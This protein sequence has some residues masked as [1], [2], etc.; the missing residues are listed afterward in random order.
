MLKY[1][2]LATSTTVLKAVGSFTANSLR[3]LR[4]K[5]MLAFLRPAIRREYVVPFRR[6]AALI[7]A[8]HRVR[9]VRLRSLRS[10]VAFSRA[11]VMAWRPRLMLERLLRVMPLVRARI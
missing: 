1:Y 7:R 8:F 4:S 9:N 11:L 10:L 6:A 3:I 5:V 2:L